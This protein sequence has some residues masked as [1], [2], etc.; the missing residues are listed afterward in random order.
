MVTGGSCVWAVFVGKNGSLDPMLLAK[1]KDFT[2]S[3]K[4]FEA[5]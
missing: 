3:G 2:G 5:E 4:S 1:R